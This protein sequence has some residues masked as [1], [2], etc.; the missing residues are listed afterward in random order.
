[1]AQRPGGMGTSAAAADSPMI[2]SLWT[3]GWHGQATSA[4]FAHATAEE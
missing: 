3:R 2:A 4:W 1:M